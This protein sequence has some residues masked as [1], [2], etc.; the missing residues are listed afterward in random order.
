MIITAATMLHLQLL[1]PKGNDGNAISDFPM[2]AF[3]KTALF[4]AMRLQ[5]V[6][7]L[8]HCRSNFIMVSYF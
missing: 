3:W 8:M 5:I 2:P 1:E 6:H 7:L 4:H